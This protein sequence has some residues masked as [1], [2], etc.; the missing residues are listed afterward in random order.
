M[1]YSKSVVAATAIA[2]SAMITEGLADITVT[3][4]VEMPPPTLFDFDNDGVAGGLYRPA[5]KGNNSRIAVY[6]MHAESD[7]MIFSACRELPRRG[8]TVFCA[9]NAADKTGVMSSIYFEDELTQADLGMQYLRNLMDIDKVVLFGYSGGGGLM[10]VFQNVAENGV[11][12]RLA[13]LN[14]NETGLID[15]EPMYITNSAYG[16]MNNKFFAQDTRFLAYTS[17]AW[18]LLHKDGLITTQ[19]VPLVRVPVNFKSYAN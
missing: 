17:K 15:D 10:T 14:A 5:T 11:S 4:D 3:P 13:A 2:F 6:V 1:F 8:F 7:Y 9:N 12:E 16:V 18:P 19:I